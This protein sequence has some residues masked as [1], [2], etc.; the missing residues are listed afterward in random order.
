MQELCEAAAEQS[1]V[2]QKAEAII[3]CYL[4]SQVPP[5]IQVSVDRNVVQLVLQQRHHVS[6]NI[7]RDAQVRELS[8]HFG[9]KTY[10]G[11]CA[12]M[13]V[14]HFGSSI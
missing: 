8:G 10:F 6:P 7:F 4:D 5:A 12:E 2:I 1:L 13:S 14:G 11:I 9:T 3:A